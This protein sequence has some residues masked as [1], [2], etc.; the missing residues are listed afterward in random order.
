MSETV[1]RIFQTLTSYSNKTL[2]LRTTHPPTRKKATTSN[3]KLIPSNFSFLSPKLKL[4]DHKI[5]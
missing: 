3:L 4:L 1:R 5:N 2:V